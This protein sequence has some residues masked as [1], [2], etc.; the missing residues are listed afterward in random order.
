LLNRGADDS[1]A[2]VALRAEL[3]ATTTASATDAGTSA[4]PESLGAEAGGMVAE[5]TGEDGSVDQTYTEPTTTAGGSATTAAGGSATTAAPVPSIPSPR[6]FTG[7]LTADIRETVL[8]DIGEST[9]DFHAADKAIR[10]SSPG[11]TTCLVDLQAEIAP[12]AMASYV[13]GVL[14]TPDGAQQFVVAFVGDDVATATVAA[15][16]LDP[17]AVADVYP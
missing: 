16:T 10:D 4:N 1:S 15:I 13:D 2:D 12:N 8:L 11:L 7:R 14:L 17:C 9:A 6:T 3:A 5:D